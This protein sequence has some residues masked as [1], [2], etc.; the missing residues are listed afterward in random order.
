MRVRNMLLTMFLPLQLF[1]SSAANTTDVNAVSSVEY[2]RLNLDGDQNRHSNHLLVG[3]LGKYP[4]KLSAQIPG[5]AEGI[6]DTDA[7]YGGLKFEGRFLAIGRV[8]GVKGVEGF[9]STIFSGD[10]RTLGGPCY[11]LG[12]LLQ[13]TG[14]GS[15]LDC[16]A[17]TWNFTEKSN[18]TRPSVGVVVTLEYQS[19][20]L[21]IECDTFDRCAYPP[22]YSTKFEQDGCGIFL[23]YKFSNSVGTSFRVLDLMTP[24]QA[25]SLTYLR[26]NQKK[27]LKSDV[28]RFCGKKLQET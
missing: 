7:K 14:N 24:R 19:E 16:T 23:Y 8:H 20:K 9:N 2:F 4:I 27:K 17:W 11:M 6:L 22:L 18:S 13:A 10:T 1:V 15:L 25:D 5:I 28:A 26:S 21:K 12:E 3:K